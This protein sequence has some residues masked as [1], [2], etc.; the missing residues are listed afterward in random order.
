VPKL[1][2]IGSIEADLRSVLTTGLKNDHVKEASGKANG[3][4]NGAAA[5]H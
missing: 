5:E 3:H 1:P 2:D 4:A